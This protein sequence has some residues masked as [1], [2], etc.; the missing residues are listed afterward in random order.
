MTTLTTYHASAPTKVLLH[1]A[2]DATV[3]RALSDFGVQ[4]SRWPLHPLPTTVDGPAVLKA[5]H[6]ELQEI[7]DRAGYTTIDVVRVTP[8]HPDRE[9]MRAKFIEEHIHHDDE[10]RFFAEGSGAFYLHLG[11]TVAQV[12]CE[13]GD[14]IAVAKGTKHW[15][16]M[17]PSPRFTAIRLFTSTDGWV[18]HFTGDPISAQVPRLDSAGAPA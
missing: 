12:V 11:D 10:V 16:D 5:Y 9:A 17:G 1:T 7:K 6:S 15:F 8:D 13:A 3:L 4:F 14:L 2:D 18:G